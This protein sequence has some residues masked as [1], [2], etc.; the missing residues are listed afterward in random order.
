MGGIV[1]AAVLIATAA[2]AI[3]QCVTTETQRLFARD[4]EDDDTFGVNVDHDGDLL[5]V[6]V[7]GDNDLGSE[8]GAAHV[9]RLEPESGLWLEEAKLH[10]D[11]GR[12][13]DWFGFGVVVCGETIVVSAKRQEGGN[14]PALR[15]YVFAPD[16]QGWV[17]VQKIVIPDASLVGGPRVQMNPLA[18]DGD[19]LVAGSW[20]QIAGRVLVFRYDSIVQR[21]RPEQALTASD[22]MQG[23]FFGFSVDVYGTRLIVGAPGIDRGEINHSGGAYIFDFDTTAGQWIEQAKLLP[24]GPP[25]TKQYGWAVAIADDTAVVSANADMAFGAYAGAAYIYEYDPRNLTWNETLQLGPSDASTDMFFGTAVELFGTSLLVGAARDATLVSDAGS[26]YLFHRNEGNRWIETAKL[27][28]SNA[29]EDDQLGFSASLD[30]E[31]AIVGSL[32]GDGATVDSGATYVY[33][34]STLCTIVGDIDGDGDV[35]GADLILL[36]GAWG[37]CDDC[38]NCAADLTGDCLVDPSDLLILLGNWG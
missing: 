26:A 21:W 23:D 36:L 13:F 24:P 15:L 20:F 2:E 8:A 7:H 34:L 4:G 17:Q 29:D 19:T 32:H 5:V 1:A 28:A 16:D 12:A 10:A 38:R 33:D 27:V 31:Y 11:D 30:Q 35:D 25:V 18:L 9:F 6:G 37:S 14:D 3:A 22:G